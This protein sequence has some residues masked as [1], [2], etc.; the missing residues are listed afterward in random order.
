MSRPSGRLF[1]ISPRGSDEEARDSVS[2]VSAAVLLTVQRVRDTVAPSDANLRSALTHYRAAQQLARRGGLGA[3]PPTN[4]AKRPGSIRSLPTRTTACG[5]AEHGAC[6]GTRQPRSRSRSAS[7]RRARSTA[8]ATRHASSADRQILEDAD[9]IRD[10]TPDAAWR[11]H[12]PARAAARSATSRRC[13]TGRSSLGA[14]VRAAGPVLA[15]G[16]AH[17][18]NGD[19]IRAEALLDRSRA[20]QQQAG[21]AWNNL[22]VI[23]LSSG[24]RKEADDAVRNAERTG[25]HVNP[26]PQRRHREECR[27]RRGPIRGPRR[28]ACHR[29]SRDRRGSARSIPARPKA[30]ATQQR[31]S[32]FR[33]HPVNNWHTCSGVHPNRT[34]RVCAH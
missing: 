31:V 13:S 30:P 25:F 6:A 7:R 33:R 23:Y 29:W 3:A 17:F 20:S 5:Q 21:E 27:I 18:R 28:S 32:N 15:L 14:S 22:A 34:A 9:E 12:E 10:T 2:S 4:F 1:L 16:S 11:R 8:C 24:R 26:Q 19:R